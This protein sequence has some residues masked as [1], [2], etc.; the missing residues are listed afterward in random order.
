MAPPGP[1]QPFIEL[2]KE[3]WMFTQIGLL[4][5]GLYLLVDGLLEAGYVHAGIGLLVAGYGATTLYKLK[6]G[7]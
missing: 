4:V 1:L 3:W 2:H 7:K 6:A 5:M